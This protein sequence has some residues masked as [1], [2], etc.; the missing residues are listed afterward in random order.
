MFAVD[1]IPAQDVSAAVDAFLQGK[2]PGFDGRFAPT[3]PQLAA[4]ARRA[5]NER[6]DSEERTNRYTQPQLPPPIVQH[7]AEERARVKAL[8]DGFVAKQVA[9]GESADEVKARKALFDATNARFY[10]DMTPEAMMKRL[11]LVP[12]TVGDADGDRDVAR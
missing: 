5:M 12:Y 9:D 6:L 1:E 4:A 10:P 11:R 2:V 8:V 3:A 7:S